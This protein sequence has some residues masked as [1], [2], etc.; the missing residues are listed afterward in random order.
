MVRR[1]SRARRCLA[2][3]VDWLRDGEQAGV[4]NLP[5]LD[6]QTVDH[7]V[8]A[9]LKRFYFRPSYMARFLLETRSASD[10]Y[11][12]LRGFYNYFRY[13]REAGQ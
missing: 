11:R 3:A 2:L 9:G 1:R 4:I 13:M 12:K 8:D 7:H 10:L 6:K 5:G